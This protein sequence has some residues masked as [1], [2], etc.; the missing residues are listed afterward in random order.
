MTAM[1]ATPVD[2]NGN[3]GPEDPQGDDAYAVAEAW[4]AAWTRPKGLRRVETVSGPPRLAVLRQQS[5]CPERYP[6][7]APAKRPLW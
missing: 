1:I 7:R 3:R 4:E 6:R 5:P 2:E